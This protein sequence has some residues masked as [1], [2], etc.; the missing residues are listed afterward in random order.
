MDER[1][2]LC[3][4]RQASQILNAA[5][6]RHAEGTVEIIDGLERNTMF[7]NRR[8]ERGHPHAGI[9]GGFARLRQRFA[10]GRRDTLFWRFAM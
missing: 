9:A 5:T 10:V 2:E 7:E 1:G 8:L 3:R 6:T 4:W